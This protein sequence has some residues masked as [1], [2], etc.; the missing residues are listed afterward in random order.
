[1]CHDHKFDPI[2]QKDYYSWQAFFAG[3]DYGDRPIRDA[4]YERRLSEAKA[5][6]PQITELEGRL[7]AFEPLAFSGN[8]VIIDDEDESRVEAFKEKNGHGSNPE[9]TKRG[10]RDDV[11]DA[12]RVGNLSRGRYTWWDN[13]SGEDV[14]AY[15][16]GVEGRYRLWISWG[17]HGSG[18]HTRDARYLLDLDGDLDTTEDQREVASVDQYYPAGVSEGE[19]EKSPLWSGL[20]DVGVHEWSPD[21]RIVLRGGETGTGITADVI[22]MQEAINDAAEGSLPR[23]RAPVSPLRNVERLDP[24]NAKYVRFTT[25][26]T[27]DNNKHEPCLDE[28]E[29]FTTG[30]RPRNIALAEHGTVPTSSGNYSNTGR[31][32]LK[33]IN[34]GAY[35]N[36]RSW[37]SNEHG[38]GWVQLEFPQPETIDRIEWARDRLGNFPDRL[39]VR[40]RIE[41]SLNGEDWTRVA[42]HEDRV[43]LGTPFD[44]TLNR[45]RHGST[46]PKSDLPS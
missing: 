22:V 45:L 29:V 10:Y 37:I 24:V 38:G 15:A 30:P 6:E 31:H 13:V 32:Q 7:A 14:F 39:P 35:G 41:V 8:T 26:E 42:G 34:D 21:S 16:P 4:D 46:S 1:R 9:G 11:G 5:L 18:V 28:L 2:T 40:Y 12:M 20:L 3:V 43:P 19:T 44:E 36:E 23:L 17:A 33:H 27:I 25:F